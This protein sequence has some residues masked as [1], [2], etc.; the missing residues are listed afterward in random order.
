[1]ATP[2]DPM[3]EPRMYQQTLLQDGLYDLLESDTFVDCVLKIKDKEFPCHRLVLAACSSFFR[4]MFKSGQEEFKKREIVLEEVE[5]DI[6]EIILKY[7]YTSNIVVTEHNVQDIF[8]VANLLQIP[9]IFTVCVS[10]LQKRLSLSNCVAIF[11]LGLML[12]C[13]R[14]AISARDFICKSFQLIRQDQDFLDLNPSELAAIIASDTLNVE[15]EEVVFE[16]L[17]KWVAHD[18][19]GRLK[20][21]PGLL[22]CVRFRLV[23]EEYFINKVENH[24]WIQSN[25]E[26]AEKLQLVKDAFN[27]KLP[28]VKKTTSKKEEGKKQMDDGEMGEKEEDVEEKEE[29]EE[30]KEGLLPGILNDNLRFGMFLRDL[31]FMISDTGAVAYDPTG[32]DCYVASLSTQVPKNHCSLVTKENQIFVAGGLFYN[33]QNKEEPLSSYFLQFDPIGADWLGMPPLPS[34]RCLFGLGEAEN[35]I[36]VIGGKELKEEDHI[37][38]T[39][40]VYD[41]QTFKWGEAD[42]LDFAVYGHGTVSHNGLVYIIGGKGDNKECIQKTCVYDPKTFEWKDLAPL[43]IAR[44]LFGVTVHQDKIYVVAGVTDT[45]LTNTVEVYDIASDKWSEFLEFPQE[46]SSISL[47][48]TAGSLYAIGGFAMIPG[49]NE[50]F[51]PKEMTDIWRYDEGERKWIGILRD[52]RYASG[53]TIL[54]VRLNILHL[55]KM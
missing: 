45:G 29:E 4:A 42:S 6:M 39:V 19:D 14:L 36:F 27:G 48:S 44:S 1:M 34:P 22:E 26:I 46:R 12:D 25:T 11:R 33:E 49:E 37:L 31:I 54:G 30:E 7:I 5:P 35:S 55:T 43:K 18:K 50:E 28:E 9:S 2:I 47:V 20:E 13:P 32:N 51:V 53:A 10:F 24:E 52:I 15:N 16:S 40:M 23:P 38:D 41:R 3:E 8:T 17:L 21:L